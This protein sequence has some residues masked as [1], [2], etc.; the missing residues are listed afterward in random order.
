MYLKWFAPSSPSLFPD[1]MLLFGLA[2]V[3]SSVGFYRVVYFISIGYA[4]SIVGMA[5]ATPLCHL[6]NLGWA[7]ALQ[8]IFLSIW[9]VRLGL[10]LVQRELR[11]SYSKA[12]AA[13]H[14]RSARMGLGR[15]VLIWVGVSFLYVLMFSPSLFSLTTGPA[16]S[17]WLYS[18]VQTVGLVTMS[19]GLLLET[20]ADKQKSDFKV[21]HPSQF[22]AVG[23][24]KTVRCPNYLGEIGFWV[25]N[26][27]LGVL[28]YDT[29]FK[30]IASLIG[31]ICIILIMMGST[32]RLEESQDH[33]YGSQP[34]YL[35]YVR[36]VPVLLPFV[37]VY[38]L[39]NIRVYLE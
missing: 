1:L 22:C 23:L 36:T 37:P 20:V 24:Y 2:L 39:K 17:S 31:V 18:L 3:L 33:R 16:V 4:F 30:W 11:Q 28:Y 19:G 34:A 12:I 8:A 13:V 38:S 9:G 15:K 25:G 27:M 26:W 21:H 35:A 7:S 5:V 32:K 10:F 6:D 29:P 14:E